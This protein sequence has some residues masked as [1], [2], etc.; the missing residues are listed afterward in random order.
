MNEKS[1]QEL[2][3]EELDV[4]TG[5]A[6]AGGQK[7]SKVRVMGL[8]AEGNT[9]KGFTF[10]CQNPACGKAFI[11]TDLNADEYECPYCHKVHESC[12]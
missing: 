8:P 6:L 3:D 5:G 11:I 4:V 7:K 12:G 10:A 2:R 1:M 9:G